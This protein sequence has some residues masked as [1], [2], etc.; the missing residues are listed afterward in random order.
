M[1]IKFR[2]GPAAAF[3]G[4]DGIKR[5]CTAFE[6]AKG[7]VLRCKRFKKG[8]GRPVCDSRLVDGGRSPGLVRGAKCAKR[9]VKLKRA[10]GKRKSSKRS[11]KR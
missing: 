4:F 1:L 3:A 10:S 6:K 8:R 2:A 7:G 11:R 5:T 9:T